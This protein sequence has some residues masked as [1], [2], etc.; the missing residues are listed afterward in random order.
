VGNIVKIAVHA[1]A[2]TKIDIRYNWNFEFGVRVGLP[3]VFPRVEDG[4]DGSLK[5]K[6]Y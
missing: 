2:I 6:K 4:I 1:S 3:G 5:L